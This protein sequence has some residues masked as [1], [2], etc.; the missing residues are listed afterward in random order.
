MYYA[1][2]YVGLKKSRNLNQFLL[3]IIKLLFQDIS[4]DR[5][6][7]SIMSYAKQLVDADR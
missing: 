3:S 2:M 4:T 5:V 6:V 1:E 7:R